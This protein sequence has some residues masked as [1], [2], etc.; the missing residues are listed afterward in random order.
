ML[1]ASFTSLIGK[2]ATA[3]WLGKVS[4]SFCT[5]CVAFGYWLPALG[6]RFL[7]PYGLPPPQ[8]SLC[9]APHHRLRP[10]FRRDLSN[11][12]KRPPPLPTRRPTWTPDPTSTPAKDQPLGIFVFPEGFDPLTGLEVENP[13]NLERRPVMVKIS[14]FPST[15]RPQSGL[16]AADIVFEYYIGEFMNRFLAI[17]YGNNVPKAGPIRSGRFVDAQLVEMYGGI[18]V[19]G[20][21]DERVDEALEEILSKRAISHLEAGCPII[22]GDDTHTHSVFA[23]TARVSEFAQSEG[24]YDSKPELR[25]MVF[26]PRPPLGDD[27]AMKVGVQYVRFYRGEWTYD[28]D[29]QTYFR[30]IDD[31]SMNVP[32]VMV[33]LEDR[34]TEQQLSFENVIILFTTYIEYNPTLHDIEIWLN[35]RGKRAIFFRDGVMTE[36]TWR[37]VNPELPIQFFTRWGIPYTLKPGKTWIVLVGDSSKFGQPAP[38]E[39]ELRFDLP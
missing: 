28:T 29:S 24:V 14:N 6:C 2:V 35:T 16:S 12:P 7:S 8:P 1:A 20:S 33:P 13:E 22:C 15:A 21:A 19:Y 30:W 17:F 39:W 31:D 18:L 37:T 36:G 34:L 5:V 3:Y 10:L 25:G 32:P 11:T 23:D 26:D 4:S 38:G 27:L 9:P